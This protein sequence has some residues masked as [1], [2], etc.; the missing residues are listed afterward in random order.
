MARFSSRRRV[1][2]GCSSVLSRCVRKH[3]ADPLAGKAQ[4]AEEEARLLALKAGEA[5]MQ[6]V[7]VTAIRGRE[8]RRLLEQ[9]ML[10]AEMLALKMAEE[11]ERR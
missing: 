8:E 10:E 2:T 11:S 9:K 7:K 3:A 5:E 6:R 4:M 1:R